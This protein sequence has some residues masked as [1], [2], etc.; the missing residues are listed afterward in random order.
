MDF[1]RTRSG[2]DADVHDIFFDGIEGAN[3][4]ESRKG[5]REGHVEGKVVARVSD[6]LKEE[7]TGNLAQKEVPLL[8]RY[9]TMSVF[10]A[11]K[12]F[13]ATHLTHFHPRLSFNRTHFRNAAS[14]SSCSVSY[15]A[16]NVSSCTLREVSDKCATV[17]RAPSSASMW[18]MEERISQGS[19][20]VC[21]GE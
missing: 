6:M 1:D 16:G 9:A 4:G 11:M 5:A 19:R 12:P 17:R 14:S 13:G 7:M 8:Y 2:F 15:N 21:Y 10:P 3:K 20:G 18:A